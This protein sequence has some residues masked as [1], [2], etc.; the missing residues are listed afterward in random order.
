MPRTCTVCNHP[1]RESIDRALVIDKTPLRDI[2]RQWRVSKDSVARHRD[3]IPRALVKA[4][5]AQEVA[6]ADTL[7]DEMQQARSRAERLYQAAEKI[8]ER[9]VEGN[10]GKLALQAIKSAVDILREA[11]GLLELKGQ[12]TGELGQQAEVAGQCVIVMP[13]RVPLGYRAPLY[14]PE[15]FPERYKALPPGE[16]N[17]QGPGEEGTGNGT[18]E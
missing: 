4:E 16:E 8:L 6:K 7:L 14:P 12:V 18:G 2:A 5:E 1:D 13:E 11:R 3:H 15:Q 9:A 17:G 10:D